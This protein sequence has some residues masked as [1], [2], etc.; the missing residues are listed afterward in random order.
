MHIKIAGRY[1]VQYLTSHKIPCHKVGARKLFGGMNH[2]N[3]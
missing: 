3:R 2:V 1:S